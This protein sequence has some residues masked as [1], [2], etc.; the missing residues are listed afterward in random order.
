MNKVRV[1]IVY[2]ER[3]LISDQKALNV[4]FIV[5]D[6][7]LHNEE[8]KTILYQHRDELGDR[9]YIKPKHPLEFFGYKQI[10]SF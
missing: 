1:F 3:E 7:T 2:N 8:I 4:H 9:E 5:V 6:G 10:P